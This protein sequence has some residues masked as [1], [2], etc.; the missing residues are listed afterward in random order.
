MEYAKDEVFTIKYERTKNNKK[1]KL[2]KFLKR[3]KV[4]TTLAILGLA[5]SIADSILII[6]FFEVLN[7]M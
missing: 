2:A 5:L 4:I 3:Y 1:N 7:V 6:E